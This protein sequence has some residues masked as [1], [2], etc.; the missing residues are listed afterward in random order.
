MDIRARHSP[1]G[2]DAKKK[3]L[4][5]AERDEP[6]RQAFRA[7]LTQ[8][9]A[10]DFV[11]VDECGSNLN[12]TPQY[13]RAPQGTRAYGKVP[14]NTPPNTSL[15]AAMSLTGMGAALV[16]PG[17]TDTA[18][19]LV[20]LTQVLLPTLPPGKVVIM[21]NLSAHKTSQVRTLIEAHGC[22]RWYLPA[23]S[24]DLSPI[25]E[26]FSKLKNS[27]RR[28]AA[29]TADA[30][31]DAIAAGLNDISATDALGYFTH[32]GYHLQAQ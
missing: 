20:Y 31:I 21:D 29:R 17:A 23:Y 3:T 18:A 25:E 4:G 6:Q 27:L 28:A 8:R 12:L 13:A 32:C 10:S 22:E 1:F 7:H 11:I 19:F 5:A 2:L 15:I 9:A 24:P 30:L 16:L 26:A 14:R